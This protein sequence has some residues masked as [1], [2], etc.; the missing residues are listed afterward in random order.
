M[1]SGLGGCHVNELH[2]VPEYGDAGLPVP[3]SLVL[4]QPVTASAVKVSRMKIV[5]I[6][7]IFSSY[8]FTF[9]WLSRMN[10]AVG[11]SLPFGLSGDFHYR[12]LHDW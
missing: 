9:I 11:F 6:S 7:V 5:F 2:G 4:W 8:C 1:V 10:R 12:K 3:V